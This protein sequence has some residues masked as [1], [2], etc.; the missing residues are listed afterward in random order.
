V[1]A[2]ALFWVSCNFDV[3]LVTYCAK[4]GR[5]SDGGG[6]DSGVVDSGSGGGP[7][8]GRVD[9]GSS[10]AGVTDAGGG[11]DGG[12]GLGT[13]NV[14]EH[15]NSPG[16]TGLYVVPGLTP[17]T[18][19]TLH[20]DS[21]FSAVI[22]DA[23]TYAQPLYFENG[24]GGK[25][26]VVVA[27][28]SNVVYALDADGGVPAWTMTVGT[29]AP[30]SM[31]PCGNI[32]PL[33]IT[34]TPV[35]DPSSRT[36][37]LDAMTLQAGAPTHEIFALS[38][39]DGH[40][41]TGWPVTPEGLVSGGVTFHSIAQSQR[42]ALLLL[43]GTLYLAYGGFFGDC[44]AYHGWVVGVPTQ[45]PSTLTGWATSAAGGGAWGPGGL[46]SDGTSIFVAT[47]NTF[48]ASVWNG[49]EAHIRLS[50]ALNFTG[51]A[52]DYW[53][54]TNWKALD[55]ADLDI[56]GSGPLLL[57]LPGSTPSAM[58]VALGKD[59]NA[60]LLDRTNLGGVAAAPATFAAASN[61]IIS[62]GAAFV[63]GGKGYAVF[64]GT[65]K[66]CP[67]G[68]GDLIALKIAPAAPPTVTTAWCATMNGSGSPM[69]TT[70]DGSANPMVWAVGAE[71]GNRL[72]GFD[73]VTGTVAFNGGG[74]GDAMGKVRRYTTP[75]AAKGRIFVAG[76]GAVYA[77]TR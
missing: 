36:L 14:V 77:F 51:N 49:G 8:S 35:I 25:D 21:T 44:G 55:N 52:P 53:A 71:A 24:P 9:S 16:R 58:D 2:A 4:T 31:M 17:A 60:Y 61:E 38:L 12:P 40:I 15:H 69:V 22:S 41:L 50:A 10:D 56:G 30:V 1:A 43:N 37:Y 39:D 42:G 65:G 19:G 68:V 59:G 34:G 27:T 7:D 45:S 75:I 3:D 26:L 62:A 20:K 23:G 13:T 70:T 11:G 6:P 32:D 73:G 64:K 76:D 29:P 54:P 63:S 33:G 72:I 5:C 57:D 47:G 48:G 74:A 46:A 66:S 18:A 28:E 67:N